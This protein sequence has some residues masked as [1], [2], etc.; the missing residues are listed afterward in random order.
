MQKTAGDAPPV[1]E[2]LLAEVLPRAVDG[3]SAK[4]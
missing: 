3:F 1:Y 2:H 4:I